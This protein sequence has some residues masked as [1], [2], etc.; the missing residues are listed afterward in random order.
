MSAILSTSLLFSRLD[1]FFPSIDIVEWAEVPLRAF[2]HDES[3]SKNPLFTIIKFFPWLNSNES[4]PA[5]QFWE[6]LL[7]MPI[8]KIKEVDLEFNQVEKA[9]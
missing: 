1:E 5:C 7:G 8:S 4:V 6:I 2:T 9:S 3:I